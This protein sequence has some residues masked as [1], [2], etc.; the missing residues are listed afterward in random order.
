MVLFFLGLKIVN[1]I[2]EQ[3]GGEFKI[4]SIYNQQTQVEV[5]LPLWVE[6]SHDSANT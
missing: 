4:A 2:V 3:V 5:I 1:K 6:M